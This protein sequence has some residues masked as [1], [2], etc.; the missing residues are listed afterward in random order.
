MPRV[1]GVD[2]RLEVLERAVLR[3]D[4]QVVGDVVP[5]VLE[6]RREEG[7][8]PD[9]RHAEPLQVV[10]LQRQSLKVAGAV[11]VAVEER[12]DVR[13]VNDRVLVP[14]RIVVGRRRHGRDRVDRQRQRWGFG[15][16]RMCPW[17][18][19]GSNRT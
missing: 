2:E 17:R 19:S 4:V 1:R 8:Q 12:L 10:Q 11:V 13:L 15:S 18:R 16:H 5:I 7:Q 14:Q 3:V 6:R 9:A